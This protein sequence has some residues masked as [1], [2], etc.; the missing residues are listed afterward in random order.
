[1]PST[2][3][4]KF[5][6][7]Y[8]VLPSKTSTPVDIGDPAK[9]RVDTLK[10]L[11]G[12]APVPEQFNILL[13]DD[14]E[15]LDHYR[16]DLWVHPERAATL[17]KSAHQF[18]AEAGSAVNGLLKSEQKRLETAIDRR[19]AAEVIGREESRDTITGRMS[20]WHAAA[21]DSAKELRD[22][23]RPKPDNTARLVMTMCGLKNEK[24]NPKAPWYWNPEDDPRRTPEN[25][26]APHK[27][28]RI[29][30][31]VTADT[32]LRFFKKH[33]LLA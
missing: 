11:K 3:K 24:W 28:D 26:P 12:E 13:P 20:D 1:M 21:L 8:Q 31:Y 30:R 5:A 17:G 18:I 16:K 23:S 9:A 27:K 14:E 29:K 19:R 15:A 7:G 2:K 22:K 33:Q 32:L 4:Q 25:D 6:I 10:W